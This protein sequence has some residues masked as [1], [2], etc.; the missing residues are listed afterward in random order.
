M[1]CRVVAGGLN[2]PERVEAIGAPFPCVAHGVEQAES[3][4][5]EAVGRRDVGEAV[6]AEIAIRECALPDIA[7]VA[8]FRR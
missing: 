5:H 1:R 8:A 3:I 6:F 2:V 7:H 4:G